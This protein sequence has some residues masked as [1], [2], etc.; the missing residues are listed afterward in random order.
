MNELL[1]RA[2]RYGGSIVWWLWGQRDEEGAGR[3]A[4]S[5]PPLPHPLV[6]AGVGLLRLLCGGMSDSLRG[7]GLRRLRRGL[8]HAAEGGSRVLI[9]STEDAH[10]C[11]MPPH[12]SRD[13]HTASLGGI[14]RA[15]SSNVGL[16]ARAI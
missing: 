14:Y 12:L 8:W 13:A 10:R 6:I 16:L 9:V 7:R 11:Y 4:N 2:S 1:S 5:T 3:V 15:A